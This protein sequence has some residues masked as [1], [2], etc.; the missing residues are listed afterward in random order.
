MTEMAGETKFTYETYNYRMRWQLVEHDPARY[1]LIVTRNLPGNQE[2]Q[3]GC[4]AVTGLQMNA[5][6]K[7]RPLREGI[8]K[9]AIEAI[10]AGEFGQE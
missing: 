4:I 1:E 2:T 3:V 5:Y 6:E 8:E 7:N 9:L 10:K